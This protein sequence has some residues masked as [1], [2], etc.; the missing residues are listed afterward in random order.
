MENTQIPIPVS[1]LENA[2]DLWLNN[3]F[4]YNG[5]STVSMLEFVEPDL[6]EYVYYIIP[7]GEIQKIKTYQ[8]EIFES[9]VE[10]FITELKTK[11]SNDIASSSGDSD[12][13]ERYKYSAVWLLNGSKYDDVA[14]LLPYMK[15][16]EKFIFGLK[17]ITIDDIRDYY[18]TYI[19]NGIDP[20]CS[21][22]VPS[23][24]ETGLS[25]DTVQVV[26][27]GY[28]RFLDWL[29]EKKDT[30]PQVVEVKKA[31]VVCKEPTK[32][33][34]KALD[35]MATYL[36]SGLGITNTIE[37]IIKKNKDSY[38]ERHLSNLYKSVK[39]GSLKHSALTEVLLSNNL[40]INT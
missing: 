1:K 24:K 8:K 25:Q 3:K 14:E 40:D 20:N 7:D 31:K 36:K 26:V 29:K 13:I 22:I 33:Q 35:L 38:S 16:P 19:L 27:T 34:K 21:W 6:K 28:M 15:D 2:F 39:D 9:C 5:N 11:F 18:R 32:P 37:L 12:K 17:S 23:V 10:V 30:P 4:Q